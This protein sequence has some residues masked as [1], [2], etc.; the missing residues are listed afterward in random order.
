MAPPGY[1][2]TNPIRNGNMLLTGL[3][4]ETHD[5]AV[6]CPLDLG[7]TSEPQPDFA[8]QAKRYRF[9][10]ARGTV[11]A[12]ALPTTADLQGEAATA[13]VSSRCHTPLWPSIVKRRPPFT[14]KRVYPSTG[15]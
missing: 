9:G 13:S 6:Q 5:V 8:L 15:S 7:Q 3:Y 2:H 1:E 10:I 12:K 14:P 11:P 4:R